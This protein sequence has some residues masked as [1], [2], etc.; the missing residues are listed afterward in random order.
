MNQDQNK[1]QYNIFQ[2]Q[3]QENKN[4][5]QYDN[6]SSVVMNQDQNKQQYNVLQKQHQENK[7]NDQYENI[8]SIAMKKTKTMSTL[9]TKK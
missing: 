9:E 5:E 6:I 2:K 7:N 8:S 3:H 1:Q 4:N